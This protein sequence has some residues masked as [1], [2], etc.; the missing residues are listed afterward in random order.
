MRW[1]KVL[2]L[3]VTAAVGVE[4][5]AAPRSEA[6]VPP[7]A[8]PPAV[9]GV[10]TPG[11]WDR[12]FQTIGF[13]SIEAPHLLDPRP[14]KAW[15]G[16]TSERLYIAVATDLPPDGKLITTPLAREGEFHKDDAIE[17]WLDPNC[18]ARDRAD[19][20]RDLYQ[21]VVNSA[22]DTL[23]RRLLPAESI[24]QVADSA[25]AEWKGAWEIEQTVDTKAGLWVV[26]ASLPWSDLGWTPEDVFE[27]SVGVL[28]ARN[29]QR[30]AAQ[31]TWSRHRGSFANCREY[32][33]FLLRRDVPYVRIEELGG[34]L[35]KGHIQL[36]MRIVNPGD[37]GT[38]T[39]WAV[40]SSPGSAP[41]RE[42][43]DI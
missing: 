3:V 16:Y 19:G 10:M 30:P 40:V 23:N 20:A 37:A 42:R 17:I 34:S 33:R 1:T 29:Y 35:F 43:K 7:F 8:T 6:I 11:E 4:G 5:R 18:D 31:R 24:S 26:E 12:G 14:G 2:V 9:D 21:F 25:D 15:F 38:A 13:Q 41:V 36:R 22:G 39:L 32:P 27:R 28:I